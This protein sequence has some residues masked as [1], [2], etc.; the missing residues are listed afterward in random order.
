M[1]ERPIC[2]SGNHQNP[3]GEQGSNLSD[4]GCS[5]FSQDISLEARETK[6]KIKLLGLHQHK[7]ALHNKGIFNQQNWKAGN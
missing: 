6:P 4:I 3:R 7:K 5:K 1:D 2:E